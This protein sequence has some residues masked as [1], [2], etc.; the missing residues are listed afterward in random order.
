MSIGKYIIYDNVKDSTKEYSEKI[1]AALTDENI[2]ANYYVGYPIFERND[3]KQIV[4]IMIVTEKGLFVFYEKEDEKEEIDGFVMRIMSESTKLKKLYLENYGKFVT[5]IQINKE[6]DIGQI[7]SSKESYITEYLFYEINSYLQNSY[8]MN[9]SDNR[10]ITQDNTLGSKIKKINSRIATLD[11]TQ[12]DA[13]HQK[14]KTH[15]RIRG[16]AGSGKT[17]L[18]ARRM[19]YLHFNYPELKMAYVFYTVSL[20]EYVTTLFSNFYRDLAPNRNPNFDNVRIL[21]GWGSAYKEGFYSLIADSLGVA[22]KKYS[23]LFGYENRL[24][25]ACSELI[26]IIDV[27]NLE[28]FDYVFIDEAQDFGLNF[29]H[30]VL[31]SLTTEGKMFYAYDELQTLDRTRMIPTTKEIF[32]NRAD[33]IVETI[34]LKKS[35]RC[36]NDLLVA[37]HALG[38]GIYHQDDEGNKKI[39]NMIEDLTLWEGIGYN[40]HSGVLEFGKKVCLGRQEDQRY[41]EIIGDLKVVEV[42]KALTFE[43]Q[44]EKCSVEI[45]RV[46]E[47]ED[48]LPEDILI[49]DLDSINITTNAIKFREQFIQLQD[50]NSKIKTDINLV[51][52]HSGNIFTR[53]DKLTYTTIFRAKGNE[54]NIVIILNAG[55]KDNVYITYSR[56][57]LFTAMTRAKLKTYIY[58]DSNG[59]IISEIDRVYENNFKLLFTYPTETEMKKINLVSKKE[60]YKA[61]KYDETM[62]QVNKLL[63]DNELSEEAKKDLM[64]LLNIGED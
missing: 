38:L 31:K 40:V 1:L 58:G 20:I 3:K 56:N 33:N 19:A 21:H 63:S 42:Q 45:V 26:T 17:I 10:T 46:L 24:D 27:N 60:T 62:K 7:I 51:N 8:S 43:E 41:K 25:Q 35:Y 30:L 13:I 12:F 2:L 61:I 48:V 50:E 59:K 52:K 28:I 37:A 39:I 44:V 53:K 64:K 22:P 5:Y 23:E 57:R 36:P 9:R 32:G 11:V 29:F 47:N 34:D 14:P 4:E 16:L 6:N 54:A 55:L 49:I 15:L 18:L